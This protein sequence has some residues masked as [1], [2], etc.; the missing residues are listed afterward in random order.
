MIREA[1][2]SSMKIPECIKTTV[3]LI[4]SLNLAHITDTEPNKASNP[5]LNRNSIFGTMH[6]HLSNRKIKNQNQS[7]SNIHLP[8]PHNCHFS[9]QTYPHSSIHLKNPFLPL[10]K[11]TKKMKTS[12]LHSNKSQ[13]EKSRNFKKS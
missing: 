2:K 11:Q 4:H 6:Y 9:H 3:N 1:N 7:F 8:L 12:F 5:N 10:N 13:T